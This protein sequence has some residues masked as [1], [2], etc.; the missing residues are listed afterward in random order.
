ETPFDLAMQGSFDELAIWKR[1]LS[2]AEVKSLYHYSEGG[3]SY[4]LALEEGR[5]RGGTALT[6]ELPKPSAHY[7]FDKV[8]YNENSVAPGEKNRLKSVADKTA[9]SSQNL[10]DGREG[11]AVM[12]E[13][14]RGNG[15]V[16]PAHLTAGQARFTFCFWVKS[17]ESRP[18]PAFYSGPTLLGVRTPGAGSGD[19]GIATDEGRIYLWS[20][21]GKT[22]LQTKPTTRINDKQWHHI[23]VTC[24]AE[25][26]RL[27]VDGEPAG[28]PLAVTQPLGDRPL[29]FGG[30]N[31]RK[32]DSRFPPVFHEGIYDDLR[33]Y[34]LALT[35]PQVQRLI[36]GTTAP[37]TKP[38]PGTAAGEWRDILALAVPDKHT[39]KGRWVRK[40]GELIGT[41]TQDNTA[42]L[43]IPT[44]ATGSYE[45]A[46]EFTRTAGTEDVVFVI[47]VG[48]S[49][50]AVVLD[51]FK[52]KGGLIGVETVRNKRLNLV[53]AIHR[54]SN[55]PDRPKRHSLVVR[56]LI[57]QKQV[58][59]KINVNNGQDVLKITQPIQAFTG[60]PTR[61]WYV[62]SK[63]TFGLAT[64]QSTVRF[65][66][67]KIRPLK[68]P[69]G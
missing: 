44:S 3:H 4:V 24:D 23:A 31:G 40:E 12:V 17:T 50:A 22:D 26:L 14:K 37:T 27:F 61:Y 19:L 33:V 16:L 56:V 6:A 69:G 48:S 65:H 54:P 1:G 35:Q 64:W 5:I 28:Q 60:V 9:V 21:L 57:H 2:G 58:Q 39:V 15:L 67:V 29:W 49:Q 55:I 38:T 8:P 41:P 51:G 43:Q 45:L 25:H 63:K 30:V 32:G 34:H 11:K 53:E 42:N 66:T 18:A 46:A 10:V 36:A 13:P 47:P 68:S 20:G 59:L 7:S 62:G 52:N